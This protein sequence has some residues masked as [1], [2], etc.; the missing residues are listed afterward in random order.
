MCSDNQIQAIDSV[1]L[2]NNL[3]AK[4]P[5]SSSVGDDPT[6]YVVRIRPHQVAERPL[7]WNLHVSLDAS[8]FV[9]SSYQ[10]GKSSMNAEDFLV[11]QRCN[12]KKI[13]N[14]HE[15][16]PRILISVFLVDLVHEPINHR[17]LSRLVVSS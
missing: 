8:N 2:I 16:S 6:V 15:E 14:V 13:K 7:V 10:R 17:Y 11:N 4:Q 5:T 3:L 1:K 12:R 9:H